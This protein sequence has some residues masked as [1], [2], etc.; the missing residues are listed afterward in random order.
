MKKIIGI[1]L[2]LVL[3]IPLIGQENPQPSLTKDRQP[4]LPLQEQV[5]IYVEFRESPSL[6][7]GLFERPFEVMV[8]VFKD[9]L[10]IITTVQS[11]ILVLFPFRALETLKLKISDIAYVIHSHPVSG[12]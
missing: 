4:T 12:G 9:N 7:L 6:D 10:Q 11:S 2:M 1:G 3:F 8:I 5:V